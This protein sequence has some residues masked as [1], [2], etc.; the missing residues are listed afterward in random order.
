M[1]KCSIAA[2]ITLLS[3]V[4][5][6][7]P[8]AVQENHGQEAVT[9]PLLSRSAFAHGYR[10]GYEAGYH[11]GN[12]D[13]NMARRA[14]TQF[15]QFKGLPLGYVAS[16]GSKKSFEMGFA[17]GLKAGYGDGYAG[18]MFRAVDGLRSVAASLGPNPDPTDPQNTFFD[19]GVT[20]GYQD[21]FTGAQARSNNSGMVAVDLK[22]VPCTFHPSRKQDEAAESSYCNGYRRGFVLGHGDGLALGPGE[23]LLEASK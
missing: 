3:L 18:K 1:Y 19:R 4:A 13:I 16:F 14:R 6:A 7:A 20:L 12:I 2:M 17:L 21:G 8:A 22:S 9:G 11:E 10:H 23:G 15:K 5:L